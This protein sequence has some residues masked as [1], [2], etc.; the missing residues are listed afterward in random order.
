M[1]RIWDT[2]TVRNAI[3]H[4]RVRDQVRE[5]P[6]PVRIQ[7]GEAIQALQMGVALSMPLSRPMPSVAPGVEEL[8][9]R[10]S[11]GQFRVFYLARLATGVLVF[12]A[13]T[14]KTQQTPDREIALA[15]ARLKEMKL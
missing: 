11:S 1:S 7:L 12:H 8:R 14:K 10:D 15:R 5:W 13:F 9:L 4:P 3:F 6:K 2:G